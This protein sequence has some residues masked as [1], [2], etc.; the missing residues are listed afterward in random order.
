MRRSASCKL[1]LQK[2]DYPDAQNSLATAPA[3][4]ARLSNLSKSLSSSGEAATGKPGH[5]TIIWGSP[6]ADW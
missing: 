3:T 5:R 1:V 2:P 6:C 4:T